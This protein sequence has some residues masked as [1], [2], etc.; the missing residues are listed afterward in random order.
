MKEWRIVR[1]IITPA[2]RLI[3]KTGI[4]FIIIVGIIVLLL[5]I[6]NAAKL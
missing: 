3:D 2:L 5:L 4:P 6:W 1:Q